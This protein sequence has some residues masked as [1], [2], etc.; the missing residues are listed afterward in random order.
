M[1]ILLPLTTALSA[2]L[3]FWIQFLMARLLLPRFGGAPTLWLTSLF[4]FQALLCLAYG[5]AHILCQR[6]SLRQQVTV[7]CLSLIFATSLLPISVTPWPAIEA[8]QFV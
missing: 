2:L 4:Y 3:L 6:L 8:L 5:Y 7:H 1:A